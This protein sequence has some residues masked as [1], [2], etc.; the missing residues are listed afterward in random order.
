MPIHKRLKYSLYILIAATMVVVLALSLGEGLGLVQ[1][2]NA[3]T[4][5]LHPTYLLVVYSI[6]FLLAP[7]L[8][9][10]VPID[11]DTTQGAV[12][13]KRRGGH[14]ARILVLAGIGLLLA[15]LANLIVYLVGRLA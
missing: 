9:E 2:F 5:I 14:S 1:G 15:L 3:Q 4:L 7:K 8:H 13:S 10:S 11:Y 12:T 6:A